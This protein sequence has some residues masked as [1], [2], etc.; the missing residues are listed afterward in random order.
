LSI[1]KQFVE[2]HGGRISADS[3]EGGG[4]KITVFLPRHAGAETAPPYQANSAGTP[5]AAVET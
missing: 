2:M 3:R 5:V 1:A 4:T